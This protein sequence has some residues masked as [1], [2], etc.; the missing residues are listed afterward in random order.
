MGRK[1][2]IEEYP[3][4]RTLGPTDGFTDRLLERVR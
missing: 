3:M 1:L 2:A 4:D